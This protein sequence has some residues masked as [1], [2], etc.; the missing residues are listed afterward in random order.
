MV[1][2]SDHTKLINMVIGF[3]NGVVNFPSFFKD[4]GYEVQNISPSFLN[5]DGDR[6]DTDLILSS[7]R[8]VIVIE[9][10]PD[11][12]TETLTHLL[13]SINMD[14]LRTEFRHVAT[15][16]GIEHQVVYVGLENIKSDLDD[17][18]IDDPAIIYDREERKLR[19]INS[20]SDRELDRRIPSATID[21][22]PTY[23]VPVLSDDHPAI[24]A[25]RVYQKLCAE[26]FRGGA[27]TD[28]HTLAEQIYGDY[29][30]EISGA[31]KGRIIDNIDI[32]LSEFEAKNG[33]R[34]MRK[35]EDSNRQYFVNTSDAFM[36]R[37][38]QAIKSLADD[39]SYQGTF[40]SFS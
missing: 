40:E 34:H 33:D 20:F 24:M 13:S 15:N 26:T 31:E 17:L 2:L 16:G 18:H 6:V 27:T 30:R 22:I 4:T 25:E 37:C 35:L 8:Y 36:D 21:H 10:E 39:D 5:T 23:F 32:A 9:C 3:T 7:N 14:D 28:P 11:V 19:K 38:Q 1:S 12:L 29:W